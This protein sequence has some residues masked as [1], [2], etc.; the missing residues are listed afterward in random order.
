MLIADRKD[1]KK[2]YDALKTAVYGPNSSR[3]T[4]LLSADGNTLLADRDAILERLA[5]T[6][7]C[8]IAHQL[9]M[10]MQQVTT[11]CHKLSAMS[12]LMNFQLSL[13]Q[14]KQLSICHRARSH[15]KLRMH[16]QS[17]YTSGKDMLKAVKK[18]QGHTNPTES[19]E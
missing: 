5:K 7:V 19:P 6:I 1:R 10:T 16:L 17:S 13:K 4:P 12:C 11:E 8:S 2:F 9:S 14:R 15:K 3:T 18:P